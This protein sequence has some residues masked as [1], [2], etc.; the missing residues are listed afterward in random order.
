M[1]ASW[2]AVGGLIFLVYRSSDHPGHPKLRDVER[3]VKELEHEVA[4][5][6]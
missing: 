3:Q 1:I 4:E 2:A 5:A 6:E